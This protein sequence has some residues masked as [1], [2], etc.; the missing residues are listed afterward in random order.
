MNHNSSVFDSDKKVSDLY[1][2]GTKFE[3]PQVVVQIKSRAK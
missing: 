1:F 3:E 2:N